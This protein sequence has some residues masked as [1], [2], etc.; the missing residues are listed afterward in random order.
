MDA[1]MRSGSIAFPLTCLHCTSRGCPIVLSQSP[2]QIPLNTLIHFQQIRIHPKWSVGQSVGRPARQRGWTVGVKTS[3]Q[4]YIGI[5]DKL[6]W[7]DLITNT[8]YIQKGNSLTKRHAHSIFIIAYVWVTI[9]ATMAAASWLFSGHGSVG[10]S[11]PSCSSK[12]GA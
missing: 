2:Q 1:L 3:H 4:V 8:E 7:L 12:Q 6:G 10:Y 11:K 5:S 9:L